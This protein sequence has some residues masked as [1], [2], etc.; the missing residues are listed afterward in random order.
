MIATDFS[1][2]PG[3]EVEEM[4]DTLL[5]T[6]PNGP[7]IHIVRLL[8]EIIVLWLAFLGLAFLWSWLMEGYATLCLGIASLWVLLGSA[9]LIL[10]NY[11]TVDRIKVDSQWLELQRGLVFFRPRN[12]RRFRVEEVKKL[13]P[14]Q[15]SERVTTLQGIFGLRLIFLHF[16]GPLAVETSHNMTFYIGWGASQ[17]EVEQVIALIQ[18]RFPQYGQ[19]P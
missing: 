13:R 5:I 14:V 2:R 15:P 12:T 10:W 1:Q 6:F 17:P 7:R 8:A 19:L 18:Q 11:L 3:F 16:G 9:S 4:A